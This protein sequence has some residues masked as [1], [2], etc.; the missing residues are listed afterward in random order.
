M[1]KNKNITIFLL[2]IFITCFSLSKNNLYEEQEINEYDLFYLSETKKVNLDEFVEGNMNITIKNI[3]YSY[4]INITKAE[5]SRKIFLD[6][7]SEFG[8]LNISFNSYYADISNAYCAD[9][10]NNFFVID[11]V[12]KNDE[13]E[14][15]DGIAI[16]NINVGN[17][18]QDTYSPEFNFDFALKASIKKP[19]NILEV[20][21]EHVFLCQ[22]EEV[23]NDKYRCLL[24]IVNN[25]ESEQ[26]NF[27]D[28][29]KS[30]II[31]PFINENKD[32]YNLSIYADYINKT[33]YDNL[34]KDVL[35]SL[36]PNE[37]SEY[38]NIFNTSNNNF[39]RIP[40]VNREKYL[41]ISIETTKEVKLKII[42]QEISENQT[43]YF[44]NQTKTQLFS[45]NENAQISL[46][47]D[48]SYTFL[49]LNTIQ[50]KSTFY[51]E[52]NASTKYTTDE[53][54]SNFLISFNS[55]SCTNN[56][57]KLFLENIDE[58]HVFYISF[59]KEKENDLKELIYGKT[60]RFYFN[61]I[62]EPILFFEF[63]P[64]NDTAEEYID[65]NLQIY[66]NFLKTSSNYTFKVEALFV[67]KNDIREILKNETYINSLT[68]RTEGELNYLISATNIHVKYNI[69]NNKEYILIIF[70]SNFDCTKTPL[71]LETTVSKVNSLIYPSERIY[72]YGE[73]GTFDRITYRLKGY[74]KYHLM[75][76][77]I[78]H[79]SDNINWTVNR[80][81][82]DNY[83]DN[84]T[85]ISFVIEYWRNGRE[86]LTMY[87]E[88]GEDIYLTIFITA[89]KKENFK[90]NYVF[91]YINSAKNGDFKNFRI[92]NDYLDY[93]V[94]KRVINITKL[95]K[96]TPDNY[97]SRYYMRIIPKA[98]YKSSEELNS[99]ALIQSKSTFLIN[100]MPY[101]LN[102]DYDVKEVIDRYKNYSVNC[103]IVTIENNNDIEL[104][105]YEGL[106]LNAIEIE[107]PI[108]GLVIAAISIA[109]VVF[110]IL[111][112]RIIHHYCCTG[113][114]YSYNYNYKKKDNYK[115]NYYI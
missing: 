39:L 81:Y 89:K 46:K 114:D 100:G 67:T 32:Y 79:N 23:D 104:L 72:H 16:M 101:E 27:E 28:D 91:K 43:T 36:I 83:Q 99:I 76:L 52:N 35:N 2:F 57:C 21:N 19:I 17:N 45:I 37:T 108:M 59:K 88:H 11:L 75:R 84:D 86:L 56:I 98:D 42:S 47:V 97:T 113:D 41:Y 12:K 1:E 107:K 24:M 68:D 109:G 87:I 15:E 48:S 34:N 10:S 82:E 51:L 110:I 96:F 31:F 102:M 50:G 14:L 30:L 49:S 54:E 70:K 3:V 80:K 18:P 9:D 7:Q 95:W 40:E 90:Y 26:N 73:I 71:I 29:S 93:D 112:V 55:E 65:V 111:I 53:R 20:N 78:G 58:S 5:L 77:E 25:K 4:E 60:S 106:E 64:R 105:S 13:I 6:Y 103:Y 66:N 38:K 85:D 63:I 22:T 94:E 74:E 115:H 44:F 92:K 62:N 69:T 61:G 33:I 8:C